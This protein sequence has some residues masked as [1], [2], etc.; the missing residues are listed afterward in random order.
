MWEW[1]W[2]KMNEMCCTSGK[3]DGCK[4][5]KILGC[6]TCCLVC[7]LYL[8]CVLLWCWRT[9]IE[10]NPSGFI[11]FF[12]LCDF[13]IC[14]TAVLCFSR[15]HHIKSVNHF[16]IFQPFSTDTPLP[17]RTMRFTTLERFELFWLIIFFFYENRGLM[18]CEI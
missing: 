15:N 13:H 5:L 4:V 12:I 9:Q 14:N 16:G 7:C 8:F 2:A 11:V 17:R 1:L 3:L 6:W 18:Y 10:I